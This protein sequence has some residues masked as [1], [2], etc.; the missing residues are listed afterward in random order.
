MNGISVIIVCVLICV[1]IC[2]LIFCTKNKRDDHID[3]YNEKQ[4]KFKKTLEDMASILNKHK[5]PF[6]LSNGTALGAHREK[7]FIEHDHDIDIAFFKGE[8]TFEKILNAVKKDSNFIFHNNW[9]KQ[10]GLQRCPLPDRSCNLTPTPHWT[11][12]TFRHKTTNIH[13]DIFRIEKK[14][15]NIFFYTYTGICDSK[16]NKTCVYKL[17]PF[18]LQKILFMGNTYNI[19]EKKYLEYVYGKDWKIPKKGDHGTNSLV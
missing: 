7:Q 18:H 5:I 9:P 2:I 4:I 1:L 10:P 11:E 8:T 19:P 17:K 15:N 16:P 6:F 3:Y 13:I 14:E 12:I